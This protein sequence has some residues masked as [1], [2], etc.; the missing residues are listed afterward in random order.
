MTRRTRIALVAGTVAALGAA[1]WALPRRTANADA[2]YVPR[3]DGEIVEVLPPGST[4]PRSRE[5]AAL[6]RRL[7]SSPRDVALAVRVARLDIEESRARSDPRSLGHAQAALAPWWDA[8]DAPPPV[9]VLRATIRQSLHDFDGA[10]ADLDRV[11]KVAPDDAQAWLTRSVVLTVRGEYD[12]ART[13]CA[14]L[15]SLAGEL[16]SSVCFAA[17]DAVTGSAKAAYERLGAA[18]EANPPRSPGEEAW[19]VST[20]AEIA[21]RFGDAAAAERHFQRALAIDPGDA[22]ALAAYADLLI[23]LGRPADAVR[24]L[25]DR[26]ANDG[27]L[28]RLAIAEAARHGAEAKSYAAM[29]RERYDASKQRG[30]VVHRREEARFRLVIDHD[31]ARALELA[32][33]NWDVQ[34]EPWDVRV[35]LEAAL[36]ANE[37]D[38]ARPALDFLA[39]SH[40]EDPAI[41]AL[42]TKLGARP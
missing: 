24:V 4:D 11:V 25:G 16:V 31:A 9:L 37:P 35:L 2:P 27:L 12:A 19:V 17:I 42:A 32:K 1:L 36:A 14:P 7:E 8:A 15:A 29:L 30:D 23:D 3:D 6:R 34:R 38:A 21:T 5:L 20:L 22:Y 13:S 40:L 39:K 33:A 10:L 26:T 18:L 41:A 28:L